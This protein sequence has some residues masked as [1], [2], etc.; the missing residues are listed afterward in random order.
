[1]EQHRQ[2]LARLLQLAEAEMRR[3]GTADIWSSDGNCADFAALIA[4]Q[5]LLLARGTVDPND[6]FWLSFL[7]TGT[8]DDAGG[9]PDIANEICDILQKLRH[10]P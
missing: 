6:D 9:R 4:A 10:Q 3:R 7:P 2:R 5:A 1:M 8:W